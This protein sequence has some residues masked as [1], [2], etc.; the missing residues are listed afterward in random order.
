MVTTAPRRPGGRWS[1][2]THP[3]QQDGMEG[4]HHS[5]LRSAARPAQGRAGPRASRGEPCSGG[6][7]SGAKRGW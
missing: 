2:R 6:P 3:L 7:G 5:I 4:W 1:V